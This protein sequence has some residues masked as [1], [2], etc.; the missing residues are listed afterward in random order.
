[1]FDTTLDEKKELDNICKK[2]HWGNSGIKVVGNRLFFF[3]LRDKAKRR[4]CGL[5]P[6]SNYLPLPTFHPSPVALATPSSC[7]SA[8][9]GVV[10]SR[11]HQNP[12]SW[13]REGG[14]Q[15]SVTKS[16]REDPGLYGVVVLVQ[17]FF[18]L[19]PRKQSNYLLCQCPSFP[20]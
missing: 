9:T 18:R 17:V 6:P 14:K 4:L 2:L 8:H 3:V 20:D 5:R 11:R 1:M 15:T 13:S 7:S 19:S 12:T 16:T 10:T